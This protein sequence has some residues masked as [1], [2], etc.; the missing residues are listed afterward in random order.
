M[1]SS[2][3]ISLALKNKTT[4]F[5]LIR[6][7]LDAVASNMF[8]KI[9]NKTVL[10]AD[11]LADILLKTYIRYYTHVLLHLDCIRIIKF[12]SL[13]HHQLIFLKKISESLNIQVDDQPSC[14]FDGLI[15]QFE[16]HIKES[17]KNKRD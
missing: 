5:I 2:I 8:R 1:H 3:G 9:E 10:S 16:E 17:E 11:K 15:E 14:K 13:I 6:K 12:E 4:V 7:P